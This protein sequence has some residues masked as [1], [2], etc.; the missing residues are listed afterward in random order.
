MSLNPK[1]DEHGDIDSN[2]QY[3][4]AEYESDVRRQRTPDAIS[5]QFAP[6]CVAAMPS[7]LRLLRS[8]HHNDLIL[9][10][11]DNDAFAEEAHGVGGHLGIRSV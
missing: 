2:D 9:V 8:F 1:K 7:L 11:E 4:C 5:A 3:R 10:L 6:P